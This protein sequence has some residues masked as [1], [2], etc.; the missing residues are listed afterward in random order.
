MGSDTKDIT[1]KFFNTFLQ[2]F[3]V[4]KKH[5]MIEEANLFLIVLN[6]DII[7]FKE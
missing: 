1:D 4:H 5:Q 6:Y 7:I 3:N 2:S